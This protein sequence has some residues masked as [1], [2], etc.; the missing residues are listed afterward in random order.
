MLTTGTFLNGLIQSA[1]RSPPAGPATRRDGAGD[2]LATRLP[3]R[4]PENRHRP[5]STPAPSTE[6]LEAQP[7]ADAIP[8]ASHR[9]DRADPAALLH[10]PHQRAD[11]RGHP[12]APLRSPLYSGEI[13]HRPALLPVDRRQGGAVRRQERHQIFLEPQGRDTFEVYPNGISTRL[14]LDVQLA[15]VRSIAAWK[16]RRSSAPATPSNTTTSTRR[17]CR[18]RWR[19]RRSRA[20]PCRADQRHHRLRRGRRP[21]TDG[22][23]QRRAGGP[24]DG[25]LWS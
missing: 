23:A 7:G 10:H 14:P 20:L 1:R 24:A 21:G 6:R 12:R 2:H 8:F 16:R 9:A 22:R 5:A 25:R 17:S 4:P 18:R 3:R 13:R 11:P 15:I 19:P